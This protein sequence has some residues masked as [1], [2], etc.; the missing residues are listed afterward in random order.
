[1]AIK[2]TEAF[3]EAYKQR[4]KNEE[5]VHFITSALAGVAT[6][7]INIPKG[8]ASLGAELID[9]GLGTETAAS[10]EKFFDDLNPFDDEAEARTIGKITTALTQIAPLGVFG[11]VKGAAMAPRISAAANN[12]ARRALQAKQTGKYFGALDFGRKALA[13]GA[14]FVG[15]EKVAKTAGAVVGSG[16]GEAIV[17][18]EDIGTL[19]DM[20]RGTS[21]EPYALSMMDRETQEGRSEAYRRLMN[22]VKFGTEGALFNLGLVGIGKGIQALRTP[23]EKG[24]AEYSDNML[25]RVYQKYLRYGL[26]PQNTG[27]KATLELKQGALSSQDAVSFLAK[28]EIDRFD[29]AL[30]DVFPAIEDT[31]FT[32]AKKVPSAQAEKIF[33]NEVQEIMQPTKGT[34]ESIINQAKRN[35]N[36][37]ID[38]Q[39]G[40]RRLK[41][42]IADD[43]DLFKVEDYQIVKD[44]KFDRL[45]KKIKDTGADPEPLKNAILNFRSSVDSMSARILSRGLPEELSKTI[46]KQIGGYLTTEYQMFNR[47]NPLKKYKPTGETITQATRMLIKDKQRIAL[48]KKRE[49]AKAAGKS[50]Q[51][52][53]NIRLTQ[54]ELND[55]V[56]TSNTDVD[57]FLKK[58]S[59]DEVAEELPDGTKVPIKEQI[60]GKPATKEIAKQEID[61][62]S[63]NPSIL[64]DKVLKPWQELL[65]GKITDPRYTFISTVGKQ[66][67]LNYTLKYMD[68]INK[69]GSVGPNKFIFSGVDDLIQSRVARNTEEAFA[70]LNDKNKFKQV[71]IKA[72]SEA[73]NGL[74]AL[75]GKFVRAPIYDAVFD[76]ANNLLNNNI[77]GQLYKYTILG[78]KAITQV[79]KTVLSAV[80]HMRNFLSAASFAL[81]N[82]AAYPNYGDIDVLFRGKGV[83]PAKDLT[84]GRVVGSKAFDE[85]L[86]Q[87][88][89]RGLRRGIFQSQVQV[90]EFKRVFR[91]FATLTPG[92]V[93][94][95]VTRGLFN[96]KDRVTK[97]Y[98]KIQDAYVAED[99]FWKAI[100]FNLERN[101]FDQ[102]FSQYGIDSSNFRQILEGN[103]QAVKALGENGKSLSD[104]IQTSVQRDFDSVT[105]QFNG[106][107]DDFV[108]EVSANLVRNQVPNYAY[109]GRAGRALRLSPFGN[110]IAFPLE[111]L[112][113][114]NNIITQ[115][116]KEINSGVPE[117]IKLGHKRLISFGLTVGAIPNAF[118]ETGK[119]LNNVTEDEME[120]LKRFVPDWSK[121]STLIPV[122]RDEKGYL[123]YLDFSYSNA[124][125]TLTRP[126]QSVYNAIAQGANSEESMKEA[127][128]KGMLTA[129]KELMKPFA[130]ESIFTQALTES[131]FGRGVGKNGKRIYN[132]ED[133][134]FIKIRSSIAHLAS[135]FKP[136]TVDQALRVGRTLASRSDNYG[137]TF[138]INDELF[139][140]LGYRPLSV[141]PEKA[142][143]FKTSIL[144]KKLRQDRALFTSPLLRGGRI[145]ANDIVET[146]KYSEAR[147]FYNLKEAYKDI[148]AARELGMSDAQI[149]TEL[150][151]RPGLKRE[152]IRNL[153]D[154]IFTPQEPTKFFKQ[155]VAEINEEL[156]RSEGRSLP[157]P[158]NQA[159]RIIDRIINKNYK[160]NLSDESKSL[161]D[162]DVPQPSIFQQESRITTPPLNTAPVDANIINTQAQNAGLSL[163]ANFASLSTADK[164]K[165]LNDLGIRIG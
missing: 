96:V 80:T 82:G 130:D 10:V 156:N 100:S 90:G 114:G 36:F 25:T 119:A 75:E 8:F 91:D 24:L 95:K 32:G 145:T 39:T 17:S 70:L 109:I 147:R 128:G 54:P 3:G 104:F 51:Q 88:Y 89:A 164:L 74:S 63:I 46:Q 129:A 81:A 22:R 31:Y 146:Y 33:L 6:G 40:L 154:G 79:A 38:K 59:L 67:N 61:A 125:D 127:A 162:I 71:P 131:V 92:Q 116:I 133:D 41:N 53:D 43:V 14:K 136:G 28:K 55:I 141:D 73:P 58:R 44:G 60:V 142:L 35:L 152:I 151:S 57:V 26:S 120:A 50:I 157:N 20:L 34:Q 108:D 149:E 105:K 121:N 153:M 159:E 66:S 83:L 98:G 87:L 5:D 47:L 76:T 27:T 155:R 52:V 84:Y 137:R 68:E 138:K 23:P 126:V 122:G 102:I 4:K 19:G 124:Y 107:F 18:D 158:Y 111:I 132:P 163:P 37:E 45:L 78:P 134:T 94:A 29:K 62:I 9:L 65:A 99:D 77:A 21:L 86:E 115:G 16:I 113:T 123:K 13:G 103:E 110:F 143:K 64:K 42:P 30:K 11:A 101:R 7:L 160:I 144:N 72:L 135:T 165:T 12:L 48:Y 112:R 140:L 97:V 69:L 117:I 1:M 15:K 139:G 85:N 118:R 150:R 161:T 148:N 49:A 2:R 56:K 93:D 106:S